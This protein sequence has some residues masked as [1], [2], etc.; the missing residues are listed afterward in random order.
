M[1]SNV[2]VM[3]VCVCA[4]LSQIFYDMVFNIIFTGCKIILNLNCK[5]LSFNIALKFE[6]SYL[7]LFFHTLFILFY[8]KNKTSL[9]CLC[10]YPKEIFISFDLT[11]VNITSVKICTASQSHA[12]SSH[13]SR[14]AVVICVKTI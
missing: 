3:H 13:V 5:V 7:I 2:C 9:R 12:H 14:L 10:I 8:K 6:L 4:L 1:Y 11:S